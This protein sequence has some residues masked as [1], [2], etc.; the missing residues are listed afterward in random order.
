MDKSQTAIDPKCPSAGPLT[1]KE[2]DAFARYE[3]TIDR[4]LSAFVEVGNALLAIQNGK[5]YRNH[6]RTFK[7]YTKARFGMGRAHAYRLMDGAA[8][9]ANLSP[10]G[11]ILPRVTEFSLRPLSRLDPDEQRALHRRSRTSS[12]P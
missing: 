10:G 4:E 2:S 9:F 11:D 6:Y 3:D 12:Q 1:E 8:I 5:L 7:E